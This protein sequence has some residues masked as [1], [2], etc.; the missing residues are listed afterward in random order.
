MKA[1]PA[2]LACASLLAAVH[3]VSAQIFVVNQDLG[4]I[5]E[6]TTGGTII[7]SAVISGLFSPEG[8]AFSGG[9]LFVANFGNGTIGE[10]TTA[11]A[12]VNHTLISGLNQPVGIAISGNTIFVTNFSAGTV[13]AYSTS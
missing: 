2:V 13:G 10:F 6:Y 3:S 9:N 12:V 8:I 11:G 4:T 5:G 1:L 7:N